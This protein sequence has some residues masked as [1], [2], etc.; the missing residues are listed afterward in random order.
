MT[1]EIRNE[2]DPGPQPGAALST[3]D[4]EGGAQPFHE[5]ASAWPDP[6]DLANAE[7]KQLRVRVIALE[8]VLIALLLSADDQTPG[9]YS[10]DGRDARSPWRHDGASGDESSR[11]THASAN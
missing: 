4:D 3:W 10:Q 11:R 7:L 1:R 2:R 9:R 8:N 5:E 6:P